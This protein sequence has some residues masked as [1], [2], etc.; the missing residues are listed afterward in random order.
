MGKARGVI[1]ILWVEVVSPPGVLLKVGVLLLMDS[2]TRLMEFWYRAIW[3][4]KV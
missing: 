4:E 2:T 3:A 1:L